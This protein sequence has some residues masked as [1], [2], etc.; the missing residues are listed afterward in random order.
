M[1]NSRVLVVHHGLGS[2]L[3]ATSYRSNNSFE[4]QLTQYFGDTI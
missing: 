3:T 1:A 2:T 4:L